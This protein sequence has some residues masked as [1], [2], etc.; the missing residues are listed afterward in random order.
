LIIT[1]QV[2]LDR[3]LFHQNGKRGELGPLPPD[4]L[5]FLLPLRGERLGSFFICN[6][7]LRLRF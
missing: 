7:K 2:P 4:E 1:A 3:D 6:V 5:Q